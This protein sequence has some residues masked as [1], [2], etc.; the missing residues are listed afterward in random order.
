MIKKPGSL[1]TEHARGGEL[2]RSL[3]RGNELVRSLGKEL[4]SERYESILLHAVSRGYPPS[5]LHTYVYLCAICNC[6]G[7]DNANLEDPQSYTLT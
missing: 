1:Q 4:P 3:T 5:V 2:Y 6:L 7:E